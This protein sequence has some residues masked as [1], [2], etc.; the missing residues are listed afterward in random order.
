MPPAKS[1]SP[2]EV[3][4]DLIISYLTLR[5]LIGLCGMLLPLILAAITSRSGSDALVEP[6]LSDYYYTNTGEI[7]VVILSMLAVFLFT[8]QGYGREKVWSFIA[9][10]GAMGVAFFPTEAP[11][12]ARTAFSIHT[13]RRGDQIPQ[14]FGL[15]EWHFVFAALFFIAAAI[16]AIVYFPRLKPGESETRDDGKLSQKGIRNRV[17]R[18]SGWVMLACVVGIAL[19]FG[20]RSSEQ[21]FK[22]FPVI[23]VLETIAVEAFGIAWIT[24]GQTLWP[25]GKSHFFK[26][27]ESAKPNG[28]M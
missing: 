27:L 20:I 18:I 15:I 21:P 8:Y 19:Y 2:E 9:G 11:F 26:V 3:N 12:S 6:S 22:G 10:L 7:F 5:N 23:F 16:V 25:D 14:F 24:K 28:R 4:N 13:P 17:Y 1:T